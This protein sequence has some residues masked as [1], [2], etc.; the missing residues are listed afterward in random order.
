MTSATSSG[1]SFRFGGLATGLDTTSIIDALTKAERIPATKLESQSS[2]IDVRVSALGQLSTRLQALKTAADAVVAGGFRGV[3]A[4]S[5]TSSFTA[6]VG[7]HVQPG[8]F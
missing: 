2:A 5:T 6:A 1:G 8:S 4:T 3:K 7:S